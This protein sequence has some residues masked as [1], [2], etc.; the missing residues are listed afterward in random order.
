MSKT[1]TFLGAAETVTGSKHLLTINGKKVLVDCGLFQGSREL[2][3]RNWQPFAFDPRELDAVIVTHAHLDHIGMLPRLVMQGYRGPIYATPGTIGLCK[4]SL[5]DSGRIQE[6]DA[7]FHQRHGTSRHENPQP[8]YG[9]SDSYEVLKYLRPV[10]YFQMQGLPGGAQFRYLPAGHILGAAFAEIYFDSGERVLMSGDLGRKNQPIIKDP[11]S[12]DFA[13][14]LV[15]ESTYGDRLHS[16]SNPKEKIL[17]VLKDA[18]Q[19]RSVVLVPS[20]AIGRTQDLLWYIHEL[21]EEGRIPH[22]PI[23]IDSPMANAATL[24]YSQVEEDHDSEMRVDMAAGR[25]PFRNDFVRFVRDKNMSKQLNKSSGPMMIISG[26]GMVTGGRIIH[27]LIHR[28][29]DPT[30]TVV[31]TGYQAE[32][33]VGRKIIEGET[34][35]RLYGQEMEV[36]AKIERLDSLSAHADYGEILEWLKNFKNAPRKTY[37]VHGEPPAQI[38]LKAK[39]EEE[40]GWQV[41]IPHQ[42][43]SVVL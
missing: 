26:S 9:E 18:V 10:H 2:R 12:V 28:L 32:G 17:Q 5:P 11:T 13:E 36:K 29:D 16:E 8:L 33:T 40:L 3:E 24:L 41:H 42:G 27:H 19:S 34:P 7:S 38:A 37:L 39:I 15:L 30:T 31:F 14:T 23:Y 20:F 4:I 22:I 25:S 21:V 1:L 35:I 43:E 6:E